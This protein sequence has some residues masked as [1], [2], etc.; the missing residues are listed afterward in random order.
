MKIT[1]PESNCLTNLAGGAPG[2]QTASL[3]LKGLQAHSLKFTLETES[4]QM[5][6]WRPQINKRQVEPAQ[7]NRTAV[8]ARS[9]EAGEAFQDLYLHRVW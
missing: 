7:P 8:R 3:R 6:C 2:P 4:A 5:L 1:E 9:T